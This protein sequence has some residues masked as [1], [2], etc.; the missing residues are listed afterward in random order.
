MSLYGMCITPDFDWVPPG[1]RELVD[2]HF[3][4]L[5]NES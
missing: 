3:R 5:A 4:K 1:Y 2:E